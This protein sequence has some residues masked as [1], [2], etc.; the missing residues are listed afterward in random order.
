MPALTYLWMIPLLPLLGAAANGIFGGR[1]PK[2]II[3]AVALSSTTLAFLAA[4]E[5][6][7]RIPCASRRPDSLDQIVFHL[8][9]RRRI[10][11][12]TSRCRWTSSP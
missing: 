6:G 4:L 5:V 8:D 11:A 3:T 10:P 1:W 12:R 2:N 7:A 9:F